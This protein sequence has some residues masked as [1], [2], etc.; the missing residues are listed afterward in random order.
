MKKL[1]KLI[2]ISL[3]LIT[4]VFA[5]EELKEDP[6]EIVI[7]GKRKLIHQI[8]TESPS[9]TEGSSDQEDRNIGTEPPIFTNIPP[10]EFYEPGLMSSV[11]RNCT[12]YRPS[13]KTPE[14]ES[15]E[16]EIVDSAPKSS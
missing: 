13:I 11:K 14:T 3:C 16:E 15:D 7:I 8:Y 9:D 10:K 5:A 1:K 4:S 2:G 6:A 12:E